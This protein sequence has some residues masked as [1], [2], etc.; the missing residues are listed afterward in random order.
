MIPRMLH[1][2]FTL[3]FDFL[4]RLPIHIRN[5][6]L[7]SWRSLRLSCERRPGSAGALAESALFSASST[8]GEDGR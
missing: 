7:Q 1:V 3:S 6:L 2:R 8:I 4:P 5:R